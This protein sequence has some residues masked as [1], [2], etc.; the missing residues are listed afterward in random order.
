MTRLEAL[1]RRYR[2]KKGGSINPDLMTAVNA[3]HKVEHLKM[4]LRFAEAQ[5]EHAVRGLAH[6][7]YD[8]IF[9]GW[10]RA[11]SNKSGGSL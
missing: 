8:S 3:Y 11:E 2:D 1:L 7:D 5:L 4:S 10:E 6:A 9:E